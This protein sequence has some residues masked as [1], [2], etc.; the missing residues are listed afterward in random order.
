M[1]MGRVASVTGRQLVLF[2]SLLL[3]QHRHYLRRWRRQG[4]TVARLEVTVSTVEKSWPETFP[5]GETVWEF[6]V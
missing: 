3:L 1:G 5:L 4:S 2:H 6:A